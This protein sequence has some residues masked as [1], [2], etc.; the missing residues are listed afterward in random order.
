LAFRDA[1]RADAALAAEY[2]QL[3]LDLSTQHGVYDKAY[4]QAKRPFVARVLAT[5]GIEL[6]PPQAR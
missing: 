5:A 2:E 6:V 3:K 4:A 1:L